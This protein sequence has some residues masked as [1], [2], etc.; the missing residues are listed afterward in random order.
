MNDEHLD[1]QISAY[2]DGDL[3]PEDALRIESRLGESA[4]ARALYDDLQRLRAETR[5]LSRGVTPARDLWVEIEPRLAGRKQ[6][7]V[8][9]WASVRPKAFAVLAA[10][11]LVVIGMSL[12]LQG[13]V[14]A[15]HE[16]TDKSRDT[17]R[18]WQREVADAEQQYRETKEALNT[19]LASRENELAPETLAVLEA[20]LEAIDTA[21]N[22]IRQAMATDPQDPR[23][24][25]LLVATQEKEL[26]LLQRILEAPEGT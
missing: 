12:F 2:L 13:P 1:A 5:A 16:S 11:A 18:A 22:E 6:G 20:N 21:V 15:P 8:I 17:A 24:L 25:R 3:E 26:N 19:A 9:T 10:A 7:Q 4:E 23:L 14:V